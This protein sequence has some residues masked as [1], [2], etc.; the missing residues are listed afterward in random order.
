MFW[1]YTNHL[2]LFIFIF[3]IFFGKKLS[4][5]LNLY[6]NHKES[7]NTNNF[8]WPQTSF[9]T[10][11]S[12][13]TYLLSCLWVQ[14]GVQQGDSELYL[15]GAPGFHGGA[16]CQWGGYGTW[17]I[18]LAEEEEQ[19][20]EEEMIHEIRIRV[21]K[22]EEEGLSERGGAWKEVSTSS[23]KTI[24]L[25]LCSFFQ[26]TSCYFIASTQHS[27]NHQLASSSSSCSSFLILAPLLQ[28]YPAL[29][30]LSSAP[31]AVSAPASS[32]PALCA[33]ARAFWAGNTSPSLSL[34]VPDCL[35]RWSLPLV[36]AL[37][38]CIGCVRGEEELCSCP[39]TDGERGMTSTS[40]TLPVLF[41]FWRGWRFEFFLVPV[42]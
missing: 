2:W 37:S 26:M 14:V 27:L 33:E 36:T 16:V 38:A 30:S 29:P 19:G 13:T 9:I 18:E 21:G 17:K 7:H 15:P 31:A 32:L 8:Y 42:L 4:Q 5:I 12:L 3:F 11:L 1:I 6:S 41:F 23:K 22:T 10:F 24:N 28:L 35:L 39:C 20:E 40:I 25:K 34:V